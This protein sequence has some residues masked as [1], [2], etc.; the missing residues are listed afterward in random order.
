[1]G[2]GGTGPDSTRRVPRRGPTRWGLVEVY[3][4]PGANGFAHGRVH[5]W[6]EDRTLLAIASQGAIVRRWKD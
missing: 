3:V 2:A 1:M 5:L 6:A 4:H